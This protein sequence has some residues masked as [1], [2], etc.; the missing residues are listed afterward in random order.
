MYVS[1]E[2][3]CQDIAKLSFSLEGGGVRLLV[4]SLPS[5]INTIDVIGSEVKA[6]F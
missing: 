3:F 2:G 4:L 5:P 1:K 6:Y